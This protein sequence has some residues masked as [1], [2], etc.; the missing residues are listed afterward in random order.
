MIEDLTF[1]TADMTVGCDLVVVGAGPAGIVTALVAAE[2]GVDVLL[3][4]SGR[5]AFDP[6]LQSLSDAA[7][8]DRH[9]HAPLSM[10]TRRQVGGTSVI[11]GGRCVPFD[12]VDFRPR[13]VAN[14]ATWPVSYD[15]VSRFFS[16][17]CDWLVCGRAVFNAQQIPT[18]ASELVPG[19]AD[20]SVTTSTLERWS[21]PTDFGRTYRSRLQ[22]APNLKLFT[23]VTGTQLVCAR[24]ARRAEY[25]EC[26][27]IAG[28]RIRVKAK[29]FVVAAGGLEST[30]LL[31][32]SEGPQ[33]G[34]LGGGSGH[35]GRWYMAH[36]EG[37]VANVR[38]TTPP[39]ST[40]YGYE[41]DTDGVYVRRRF[42]FV[43]K[44]QIQEGLPNVVAWL[45]NPE[46]PDAHHMSGPLS[47]VYLV[48]S[49]PLG[50]WFA[51][52]VQRL[53][54]T[55]EEIPG[56]PYGGSTISPRK[57]HWRNVLR[58]P[59][60][61]AHFVGDFGAHRFLARGRRAPGFFVYSPEN[62]YPLQYH[63]EHIPNSSSRVSLS[64]KVDVLGRRRLNVELRFSP[65]D[66][67]GIVRAHQRW[68][69][70]LRSSGVGWLEYLHEDVEDAVTRRLGGGFHQSGTTR[71]STTA[72]EG[73]VDGN[74]AVHG[75]ENVHV[76]SSSTFVTS[77]QANSTFMV[78]AFALRL[79]EYL[80][81]KLRP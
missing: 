5:Q 45:G 62:V 23:G 20:G 15:E 78:V 42:A 69:A 73:V 22:Q 13:P 44:F 33:G 52:E 75:V 61:T 63:G 77:G 56:T 48:L 25:L 36:V 6:S 81:S 11:W 19:L 76:A 70:Y 21:L 24:D 71:M 1:L 12:P 34:P 54:L 50:Q 47:F 27:T 35:L 3:V 58:E 26:R 43:E 7:L 37:A 16:K 49:S 9:R 60:R 40:V 8:L 30:R 18:L 64:Q 74:L 57:A 39:R 28:K 29:E 46:L 66:V 59:M 14:S 55:G 32:T 51:P 65:A 79:A 31:M 38:F 2:R 68:D 4:E 41:R 17:A 10:A 53:S 67:S 72:A 80:C